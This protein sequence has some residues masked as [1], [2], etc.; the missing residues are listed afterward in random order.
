MFKVTTVNLSSDTTAAAPDYGESDLGELSAA[1]VVALLERLAAID[2]I[3]N[4]EADPFVRIA[5]PA[6]HFLVRTS[7]GHLHLYNARDTTE[8]GTEL[9]AEKI[10]AHLDR[11]GPSGA[12]PVAPDGADLPGRIAAPGRGIAV[13]ILLAGLAL[14][15]YTLYSAFYTESVHEKIAVTLLTDPA[16]LAAQKQAVAGTYATGEKSGDRLISIGP[17]G[18]VTFAEIGNARSISNGSDT[19]RI[20]RREKKICLTTTDSGVID[21]VNIDTVIYYRDTYRRA[22]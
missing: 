9:T 7:L 20:G 18:R 2:A 19:Y 6:G 22:R 11:P 16:E 3:Q 21:V 8:P 10:V 1:Q 5:A 13:A 17:D 12:D 14:N 4:A 15:G